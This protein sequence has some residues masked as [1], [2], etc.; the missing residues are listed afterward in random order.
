MADNRERGLCC[1]ATPWAYCG[2]VH[3]Q[4]QKERLGQACETGADLLVTAC[5]K[6]LIHFKCA[7]K[8]AET[9]FTGLNF[10]RPRGITTGSSGIG[11]AAVTKSKRKGNKI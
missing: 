1:G 4:I 9:N 2:T 8:N 7:Q 3:K 6:C 10:I 5:P 11:E